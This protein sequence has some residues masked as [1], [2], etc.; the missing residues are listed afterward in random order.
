MLQ[1]NGTNISTPASTKQVGEFLGPDTFYHLW[2]PGLAELAKPLHE[3]TKR[4][5]DLIGQ[6]TDRGHLT[7][8]R[9][10]F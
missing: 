9:K 2:I 8:S 4:K 10:G 6:R 7:P 1:G 5:Q 3:A